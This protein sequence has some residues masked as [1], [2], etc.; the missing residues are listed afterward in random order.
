MLLTVEGMERKETQKERIKYTE[1]QRGG[2]EK[3]DK[4]INVP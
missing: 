3:W 2:K 1:I 4:G